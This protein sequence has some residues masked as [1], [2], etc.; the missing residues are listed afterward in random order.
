MAG[1]V[2][3]ALLCVAVALGT[4]HGIVQTTH[5]VLHD[6]RERTYILVNPGH[7]ESPGPNGVLLLLHGW[8]QSKEW[9]CAAMEAN[10]TASDTGFLVICPQRMGSAGGHRRV[11]HL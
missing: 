10:K 8:T 1:R 5:T 3:L 7:D 9:A 6:G 4:A 2:V 11:C